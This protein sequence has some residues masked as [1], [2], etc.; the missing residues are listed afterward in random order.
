[1]KRRI[2]S[3]IILID[4]IVQ[5]INLTVILENYT[6]GVC[7]ENVF[8]KRKTQNLSEKSCCND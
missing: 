5:N 3:F 8:R 7:S 6:K 4:T 2:D 1:M